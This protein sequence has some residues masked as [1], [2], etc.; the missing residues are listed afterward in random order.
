MVAR[1][2]LGS[3]ADWIATRLPGSCVSSVLWELGL[4]TSLD[5][6]KH[7]VLEVNSS[8]STKWSPPSLANEVGDSVFRLS[9]GLQALFLTGVCGA[10]GNLIVKF[11]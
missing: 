7:L 5:S 1:M 11:L 9:T 4:V 10:S 6:E 8:A 3:S 2:G